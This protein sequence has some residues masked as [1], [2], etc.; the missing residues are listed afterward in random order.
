MIPVSANGVS[1]FTPARCLNADGTRK[2]G[3]PV[4]RL[5]HWTVRSRADFAEAVMI[6]CGRPVTD[7]EVME[8]ACEG[9]LAGFEGEEQ[10]AALATLDAE[11][12]RQD[13]AAAASANGKADQTPEELEEAA[14]LAKAI[15]RLD[16]KL[17]R[18]YPPYARV[19]AA[20]E[21][22]LDVMIRLAAQALLRGWEGV[23][24]PCELVG[25]RVTEAALDSLGPVDLLEVGAEALRRR[26]LSP[27]QQKN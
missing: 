18:C 2:E 25:G 5:A 17:S 23:E 15:D 21:K 16:L 7:E 6:A 27:Q 8:T 14:A 19:L 11:K 4:Y 13:R 22:R 26:V 20:Q 3:A 10:S 1:D 24:P 9:V 12:A